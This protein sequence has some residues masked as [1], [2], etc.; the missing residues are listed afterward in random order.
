MALRLMISHFTNLGYEPI[1]GDS[2]TADTPVFVR[3]VKTGEI[4]IR[5]ICELIDE[6]KIEVDAL[7]REYDY[8]DKPFQVLCRSGWVSPEYIYRHKT[9]KE[10]FEVCDGDTKI[11]V[12]E[13]HSL[14]NTNQEKIKP[15]E[16]TE[17]TKL[18]YFTDDEVFSGAKLLTLDDRFPEFYAKQLANGEID[19]VPM[20]F[21]NRPSRGKK[22]YDIFMQNQ[23][24]DIQ[25][26]KTCLAGL[27]FLR[28][29]K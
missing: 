11:E 29:L 23:R 17:E 27:Q 5:P 21:L 26:S 14:F 4:D 24:D 15:S 7:G 3:Y 19:R 28:S 8:S 13:D 1:V 18:E 9:D 20:W 12:T 6:D 25:Y 16:I 22:F 10:I 2:F